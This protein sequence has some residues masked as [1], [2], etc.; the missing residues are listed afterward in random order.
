MKN[1][2]LIIIGGGMVGLAL[3]A[4]LKNTAMRIALVERNPPN[5]SLAE[6]GYRVSAINLAS[7]QLL[8]TLG[9]WHHIQNLRATAYDQM[10]VWEKT[11]LPKLNLIPKD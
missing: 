7:E 1:F 4:K 8:Q 9:A 11:A 6:I 5:Q 3:A 10:K 2:D